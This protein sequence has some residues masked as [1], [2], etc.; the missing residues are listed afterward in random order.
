MTSENGPATRPR[1]AACLIVKDE[2][3]TLERCLASLRPFVDEIN[4]YDTGSS[5]GT[6]ELV[7]RLAL[8]DGPGL[9]SIRLQRGEWRDD[10]GWARTQSF[11]MASPEADW[12]LWTDADDEVEG[13]REIRRLVAESG[14]DVDTF[15]CVYDAA[16]DRDGLPRMR[17]WRERLVRADA[18]FTWQGAVHEHLAPPAHQ[19]RKAKRV[20]PSRLRWV[21]R[22]GSGWEPFRNL[23]IL[24]REF[25]RAEAAG[26]PPEAHVLFYLGCEY[27]WLG[28]FE[29]ASRYF[30]RWLGQHRQTGSHET[31]AVTN[32]LAACLRMAGD[33]RAAIKLELDAFAERKDWL[34]TSIGLMQSYA[35]SKEWTSVIAWARSAASL[36]PQL[37]GVSTSYVEQ[38]LLP[39]LRLAEAHAALGEQHAALQAFRAAVDTTPEIRL[40]AERFEQFERMLTEGDASGAS[41]VARSVAANY[42]ETTRCAARGLTAAAQRPV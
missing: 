24:A 13:G 2:E 18:G 28:D 4:I 12:L 23:T 40:L 9:A 39:S 35:M 8:A 17:T 22:E 36:E 37:T 26:E 11:A 10:F 32:K 29:A 14:E 20:E 7:E 38:R 42:D 30:H 41:R 6:L 21:H 27:F 31:L 5:D 3:L 16:L 15:V 33:V 1:I 34:P 19:T 25:E